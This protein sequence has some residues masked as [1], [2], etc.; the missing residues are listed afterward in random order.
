M[1]LIKTKTPWNSIMLFICHFH[2]PNFAS[3]L[4]RLDFNLNSPSNYQMKMKMNN[5][6]LLKFELSPCL[7]IETEIVSNLD[8]YVHKRL[9]IILKI[10]LFLNILSLF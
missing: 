6:P 3:W 7:Q 1:F 2:S 5:T 8:S 4:L 10:D 9:D